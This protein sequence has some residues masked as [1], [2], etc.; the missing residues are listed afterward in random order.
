M[1]LN[2]ILMIGGLSAAMFGAVG[3]SD[4]LEPESINRT[5]YNSVIMSEEDAK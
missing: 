1:K 5:D 2:K 3:C 4:W